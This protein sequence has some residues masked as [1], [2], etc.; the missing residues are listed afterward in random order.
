MTD[1]ERYHRGLDNCAKQAG[2]TTTDEIRELWLSLAANYR[3]L[4]D[5]EQRRNAL[6]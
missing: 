3:F 4:L 5:R 2:E 6:P 1:I